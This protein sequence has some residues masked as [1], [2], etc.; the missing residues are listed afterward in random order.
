MLFYFYTFYN[1]KI[2]NTKTFITYSSSFMA[3]FMSAVCTIYIFA[4]LY[5]KTMA[6]MNIS[7]G[8][9]GRKSLN[10]PAV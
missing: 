1:H 9:M 3:A 6:A 7:D 10:K 8:T 4:K 2:F 5:L